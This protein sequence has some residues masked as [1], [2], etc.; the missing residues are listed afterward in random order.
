MLILMY[1]CTFCNKE[2]ENIPHLFWQCGISTKFWKEVQDNIFK[3]NVNLTVK[4]VLLGI[5]DVDNCHYNFVILQG[6]KYI[7][8]ARCNMNNLDINVFKIMLKGVAN[9]EKCI[10]TGK[11][12]I[13][14]WAKR[15]NSVNV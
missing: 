1:L 12:K 4:D 9:T 15:W 11:G 5:L 14:E 10:A 8:N 13:N 6:K 3:T 7:Y 2:I